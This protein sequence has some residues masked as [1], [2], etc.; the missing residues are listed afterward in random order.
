[1]HFKDIYTKLD[2]ILE[3][4]DN[5]KTPKKIL[6]S[7]LHFFFL[8]DS[9]AGQLPPSERGDLPLT[10]LLIDH[11]T[12]Q[13]GVFLLLLLQSVNIV[14]ERILLCLFPFRR[15]V[16]VLE[17]FPVRSLNLQCRQ[18]ESFSIQLAFST[19]LFFPF[20][21]PGIEAKFDAPCSNCLGCRG[22]S[23]LGGGPY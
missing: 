14:F 21:P 5:F 7:L 2:F 11:M 17:I 23:L 15:Q 13:S 3:E 16:V 10:I 9:L 19:L 20:G 22:R 18:S 4:K 6:H 8:C 1:M 12:L